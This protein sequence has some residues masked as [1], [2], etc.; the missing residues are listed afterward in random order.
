MAQFTPNTTFQQSPESDWAYLLGSVNWADHIVFTKESL[1]DFLKTQGIQVSPSFK[2]LQ[3]LPGF[4]TVGKFDRDPSALGGA[5]ARAQGA[6]QVPVQPPSQ[7]VNAAQNGQEQEQKQAQ[8]HKNGSAPPVD[9]YRPSTR[10]T[11][12]GGTGGSSSIMLG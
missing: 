5:E 7:A 12:P 10:V 4:A 9:V 3:T 6:Q 2:E 11:M 8:G 1:V